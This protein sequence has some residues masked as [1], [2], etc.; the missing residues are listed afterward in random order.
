MQIGSFGKINFKVT[1]EI[2]KIFNDLNVSKSAKYVSHDRIGNKPLLQFMGLNPDTLTL[3]IKLIQGLT[4][5]IN[6]D[7]KELDSMLKNGTNSNFYMGNKKIGNFVIE[8]FNTNHELI[9]SAGTTD[10]ANIT[11]NLKEYAG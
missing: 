7:L 11:L 8:S 5:D 6:T 10:I 2:V 4:G 1:D 3:N 9:S